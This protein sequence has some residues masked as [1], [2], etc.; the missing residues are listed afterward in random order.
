MGKHTNS[1][2]LEGVGRMFD[3]AALALGLDEGLAEQIKRC[4]A[5]YQVQFPVRLR[6]KYE[7][8]T[9]WMAIHSEHRLPVKGG[10]RYSPLANQQEVEALASLMT[11]KNAIVDVPYG[12]S[13][14]ALRI[15]P[16]AWEV[17]ELEKITRYFTRE[18]AR[19]G[20]ISPS[21]NV[22]A[23]DMGTGAREMAWIAN[24]YRHLRPEELNAIACVTGKPPGH[25]G[26]HGREEATGRG[27]Q[28]ALREFFRDAESV[29]KS[30]L[31]GGLD[32][33]RIVVQ[34]LGNVGYHCAKFLSEEDGVRVVGIAE[35]DGG[36]VDENGLDVEAVAAYIREHRGVGGFPGVQ[37][38]ADGAPLL[39]MDCDILIPAALEG[40]I[41]DENAPRIRARIV[42]EAANGP[43]TFEADEI[44]R[45][46]GKTILPDVFLNAGGVTVSYFE[47]IKNIQHIRF[48]RMTQRDDEARGRAVVEMVEAMV[49]KPVPASMAEAVSSGADELELVRA[50]LDDTMRN[51]WGGIRATFYG[52]E[53][54]QDYR[55]AAFALALGKIASDYDH[56]GI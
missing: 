1:A 56:M 36:I 18:L 37:F 28:F 7:I 31:Q 8:F 42:A 17:D 21:L 10:I 25:G 5:T 39:E 20:F 16:H 15:D 43:V 13:K 41:N 24:E 26:I 51:A 45:V 38:Q 4:S 30:G 55:T 2:F 34:G 44:L 9:G 14:G 35:R 22:P 19:K 52:N 54:I 11:I 49:G 33:K 32:G 46:R 48:G 40:Q 53:R 23:P 6:G 50:G 47:W 12:G 3:R 27:I 29:A